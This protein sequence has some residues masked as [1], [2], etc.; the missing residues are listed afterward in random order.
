[1]VFIAVGPNDFTP[2]CVVCLQTLFNEGMK[3]EKLKHHLTMMHPEVANKPKEY[4]ERQKDLYLKQKNKMTA[5]ATLNEKV[6]RAPYLV[7]SRIAHARKPHTV[8]EQLILP[9][10]F[11]CHLQPQTC[12]NQ[13]F[14]VIG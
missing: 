8:G 13:L 11:C 7:A 10:K 4:F 9:S 3:P 5:C 12:V 6:L 2:L 1:M 14:P